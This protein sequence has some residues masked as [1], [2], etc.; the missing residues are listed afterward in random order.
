MTLQPLRGSL[1]PPRLLRSDFS[2]FDVRSFVQSLNSIPPFLFH[3][4]SSPV[5]LSLRNFPRIEKYAAKCSGF[6]GFE[7]FSFPFLR[8]FETI[9]GRFVVRNVSRNLV[10]QSSSDNHR[11]PKIE[12]KIRREDSTLSCLHPNIV[13]ISFSSNVRETGFFT[14]NATLWKKRK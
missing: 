6:S 12:P 5:T 1:T 14:N 11:D 10:E 7:T 4:T 13:S 2:W 3:F 8:S 9:F